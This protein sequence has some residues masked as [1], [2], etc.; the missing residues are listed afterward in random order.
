[1]AFSATASRTRWLATTGALA[2]TLAL[3]LV[4]GTASAKSLPAPAS[5]KRAAATSGVTNVPLDGQAGGLAVDPDTDTAYTVVSGT[6]L[7]VIDLAAGTVTATVRIGSDLRGMAVDPDTDTVYVLDYGTSSLLVISGATNTVTTTITNLG[8]LSEVDNQLA[9]NPLT[10]TIYVGLDSA[11]SAVDVIDGATNTIT[12]TIPGD[13]DADEGFGTSIA[14]DT[15]TDLIYAIGGSGSADTVLVINGATNSVINSINLGDDSYQG[16][17]TYGPIIAVDPATDI[18]YVTNSNDTVTSYSGATNALLG[19]VSVLPANGPANGLIVNPDTNT[20]Y[21]TTGD[22]D[23]GILL[24]I[25]GATDTVT[26][27]VSLPGPTLIDA[28]PDTDTVVGTVPALSEL[29]IVALQAP[30][31]SS[32]ASTTFDADQNNVFSFAATGTP[33]PTFSE[34]GALPAGVTW[35]INGALLGM[36]APQAVGSYPITVTAANGVAPAATQTFTLQVAPTLYTPIGPSRILDTRIGLGA[37]QGAVPARA[38]LTVQIAGIGGT[39][40]LSAVALNVT[41]I[42]PTANGNLTVFTAV[43]AGATTSNIAFSAGQTV[44]GL[45]T[46]TPSDGAVTIQNNSAGTVQV[47]ADLD[48][49]YSDAGAGF[50][51]VTPVRVMD[52]RSDLGAAGPVPSKGVARLNLSG[53]VPAGATAAVLNLTATGPTAAGDIIAYAD[54]QQELDTSNLNFSAGQTAANEVIVPLT[55][56]IGDFYNASSGKV[57]LIAD[58]SGY[59]APGAPGSFVPYGPT[60]IADTR[61][62][63]GVAESAI[64]AGGTLL[65]PASALHIFSTCSA[66]NC[67]PLDQADVLNV[68]V[69]APQ[70]AGFLI[71]YPTG[72]SLPATS[73]VNFTAGRTVADPVVVQDLNQNGFAIHNSSTGTVQVVVDEEGYFINQP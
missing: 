30:S 29:A 40:A 57:Q 72:Q 3:G 32:A 22:L 7:E 64:P 56:G 18:F 35:N 52:T 21:T 13:S 5:T 36:P 20:V 59:Y 41:A 33:A 39:T 43:G 66:A 60:R 14:V 68:T 12:A 65:V 8:T 17:A 2:F 28:D 46:I 34:T 44:A 6:T 50:Q 58:L 1:M 73:S 10:D 19:T 45:V 51:G 61:I 26:G 25:D 38:D 71:V 24:L 67:S 11:S 49:Y 55:N 63:L 69:T 23:F 15:A 37:A 9:V 27:N 70:A 42:S 54:G 16:Y 47:V 48:G 53:H 62:G 31:I 4:P